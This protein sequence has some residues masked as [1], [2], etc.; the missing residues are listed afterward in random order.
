MKHNT[1]TIDQRIKRKTSL[2]RWKLWFAIFVCVIILLGG[3]AYVALYTSVFHV[4]TIEIEGARAPILHP[5]FITSVTAAALTNASWWQKIIGPD[6]TLFW[7][8]VTLPH[9]LGQRDIA[10][11]II[12]TPFFSGPVIMH[13]TERVAIGVWCIDEQKCFAFDKDGIAFASAPDVRGVL[14]LRVKDMSGRRT[15]HG[16]LVMGDRKWFENFILTISALQKAGLT[17]TKIIIRDQSLR[18]WVAQTSSGVSLYFSLAFTPNNLEEVIKN[19]K[20]Q[21]PI[22]TLEY[23][24]FRVS[25]RL[26][27]R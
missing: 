1:Y 4:S 9:M 13:V 16:G 8:A 27:Y 17:P 20:I 26:Y 23:L 21:I 2:L 5:V 25:N 14:I 15:V 19:L 12:A 7:N 10:S 6:N 3:I 24:D 22:D 11:V 18:E